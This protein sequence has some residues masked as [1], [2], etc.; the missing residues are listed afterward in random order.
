MARNFIRVRCDE[1]G[2]EQIT[3]SHAASNVEC[4]VCGENLVQPTGGHAEVQGE[5]VEQHTVE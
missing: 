3:F 4:L 2:N 5:I 1:C